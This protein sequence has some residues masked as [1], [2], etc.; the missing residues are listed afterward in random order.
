MFINSLEPSHSESRAC[1]VLDTSPLWLVC[2]TI[3]YSTLLEIM[4][5][6]QKCL[7]A[8]LFEYAC[9]YCKLSLIE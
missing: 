1:D 3:L 8:D 6:N 7:N 4:N 5:K 9:G 2:T